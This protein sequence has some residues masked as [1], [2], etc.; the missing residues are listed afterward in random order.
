MASVGQFFFYF[1]S[2][3]GYNKTDNGHFRI[4][5]LSITTNEY[6]NVNNKFGSVSLPQL[7]S[8]SSQL[9]LTFPV[10]RS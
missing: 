3:V 7:M 2:L 10:F 5:T 9:L 1:M 6:K 8:A 4:T